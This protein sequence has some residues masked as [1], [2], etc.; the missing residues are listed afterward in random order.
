MCEDKQTTRNLL[1]K[2]NNNAGHSIYSACAVSKLKQTTQHSGET[3]TALR[4]EEKYNLQSASP[5]TRAQS[6]DAMRR[7]CT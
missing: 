5:H 3:N 2:R 4:K 7:Q 1:R 6:I